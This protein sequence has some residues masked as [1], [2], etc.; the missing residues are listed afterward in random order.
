MDG[1]KSHY[2]PDT[3]RMAAKENIILFT[4]PPNTTHLTQPLDK[5]PFGPL[6][7]HWKYECYKFI[8]E[9]PGKVI[10]NRAFSSIFSIAWMKAMTAP[11]IISGFKV[12][13][14]YPLDRKAIKLPIQPKGPIIDTEVSYLPFYSTPVQG[15]G[16]GGSSCHASSSFV[17]GAEDS[18][19]DETQFT[20]EECKIFQKRY[21][22]GYDLYDPR[23]RH[24]LNIFHPQA[25][26]AVMC[27]DPVSDTDTCS[28][29]DEYQ[30]SSYSGSLGKFLICPLAPERPKVYYVQFNLI[31]QSNLPIL[32]TLGL[33][34]IV[35]IIEVSLFRDRNGTIVNYNRGVLIRGCP[36]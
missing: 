10:N 5:G 4:L 23:Y 17:T 15:M 27:P 16:K 30:P 25:N 3:I 34:K 36:Q 28:E 1:H 24:W 35:L 32:D 33:N 20:D 11:N 8:S 13:G 7:S 6:K 29:G 14:I 22:N 21:E 18:P 26:D 2:C 19:V 9:N 31:I 12:T